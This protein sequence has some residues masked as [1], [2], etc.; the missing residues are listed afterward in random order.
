MRRKELVRG[1]E[2]LWSPKSAAIPG[3]A[4]IRD[5]YHLQPREQRFERLHTRKTRIGAAHD[6]KQRHA[7][8][9]QLIVRYD[10]CSQSERRLPVGATFLG[11]PYSEPT[12]F[13]LAHAYEQ[14]THHRVPPKSTPA[15]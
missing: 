3:M 4:R 13:R 14:A 1:V 11:R 15:L 10:H 5:D 9:L 2:E 6:C 8:G 12:L 7:D